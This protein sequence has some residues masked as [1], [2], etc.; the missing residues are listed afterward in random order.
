M[1]RLLATVFLLPLVVTVDI[2]KSSRSFFAKIGYVL[3]I[4]LFTGSTWITAYTGTVTFSKIVLYD[5][6]ITN[7]L[8][9][10]PVSG[11][12]MLPTIQDGVT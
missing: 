4:W 10:V 6:G 5:W 1:K 2:F 12:S 8:T 3:L 7:R 9:K 11:T